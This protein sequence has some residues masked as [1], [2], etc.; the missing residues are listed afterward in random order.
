M[1]IQKTDILSQ[2]KQNKELLGQ[3][4]ELLNPTGD[5]EQGLQL[6][7]MLSSLQTPRDFREKFAYGAFFTH[8]LESN[9]T[10]FEIE[11]LEKL[12]KGNAY[13]F[14]ANHRDII[15]D[16]VGLNA[17]LLGAGL[18]PARPVVGSNLHVS[19]EASA[20]IKLMRGLTALRVGGIREMYQAAKD[21]SARISTSLALGESVWI[22][23]RAGRAKDGYDITE[24]VVL[25]MLLMA[26]KDKGL[27]LPELLD[28]VHIVPVSVSYEFDPADRL[29]AWDY[30]RRRAPLYS[31]I[32]NRDIHVRDLA[33][34]FKD[35]AL[36]MNPISSHK[37]TDEREKRKYADAASVLVSIRRPKGRVHMHIADPIKDSKIT[38]VKELAAAIDRSIQLGQHFYPSNFIAYDRLYDTQIYADYYSQEEQHSFLARFRGLPDHVLAHALALYAHPIDLYLQQG[39]VVSCEN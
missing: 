16:T 17:S 34:R 11:G 32:Y 8:T 38:H 35:K 36:D 14:I 24:P 3:L 28:Q 29:K 19:P 22:A 31:V 4:A 9:G 23:Q 21:L 37:K 20:I 2:L 27:K 15:L 25:K 12:E 6:Q 33:A 7:N 26:M 1:L 39:G 10:S 5:P 30:G 13:L 18:S